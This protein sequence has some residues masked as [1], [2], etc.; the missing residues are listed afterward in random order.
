MPS[1]ED[2]LTLSGLTVAVPR[3]WEAE[4]RISEGDG[5]T[6]P[7]RGLSLSATTSGPVLLH[8]ANF[9]LPPDRG[10]YGSG[11]VE[12]MDSG[13]IFITLWEYNREA[14][15]DALFRNEGFP[16]GLRGDDFSP[17]ALQRRLPG[18]GGLQRFFQSGGRA[19]V[20]YVVIGSHRARNVLAAETNR[21]LE[22][23]RLV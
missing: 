13:A 14:T 11:A 20:L 17:D 22:G 16:R 6:E 2:S 9:A 15:G 4:L 5:S 21:I 3:G 23:I 8:L 18:Q 19:F 10:D 1:G 7:A 12:T